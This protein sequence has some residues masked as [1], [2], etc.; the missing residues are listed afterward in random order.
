MIRLI[1]SEYLIS[2]K[3]RNTLRI[4]S[5][6]RLIPVNGRRIYGSMTSRSMRAMG[7]L[8]HLSRPVI[9]FAYSGSAVHVQSLIRYSMMKMKRVDD[10]IRRRTVQVIGC[11]V[12]ISNILDKTIAA[13]FKRIT[14]VMKIPKI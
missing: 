6:V 13:I 8:A 3:S 12:R 10:E 1:D 4:T 11:L 9:G 14:A 2:L 5:P 7:V